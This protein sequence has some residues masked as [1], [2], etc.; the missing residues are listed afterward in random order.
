MRHELYLKLFTNKRFMAQ[1]K[2][3]KDIIQIQQQGSVKLTKPSLCY[4]IKISGPPISL[5][6]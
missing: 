5:F 4:F 6:E 3:M 2:A 1:I